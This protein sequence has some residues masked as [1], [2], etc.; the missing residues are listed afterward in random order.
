MKLVTVETHSKKRG[1]TTERGLSPLS[2]EV[3]IP[4]TLVTWVHIIIKVSN[5][6]TVTIPADG[7]DRDVLTRLEKVELGTGTGEATTFAAMSV[8]WSL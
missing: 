6:V 8:I 1:K 7:I 3:L 4:V 5:Y 2:M